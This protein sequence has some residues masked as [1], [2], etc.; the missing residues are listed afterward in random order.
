MLILKLP[1]LY[2]IG[3]SQDV[4]NEMTVPWGET[5]LPTIL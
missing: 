3:E 5:T 4:T 1:F 2:F